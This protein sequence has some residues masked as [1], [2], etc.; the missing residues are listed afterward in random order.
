LFQLF[1][2]VVI[3][4]QVYRGLLL[5]GKPT[6]FGAQAQ[7]GAALSS[8][9][10]FDLNMKITGGKLASTFGPEAYFRVVPQSHSTFQGNFATSFS[11]DKPLTNLRALQG[12]LPASVPEPS[13]LWVF[14]MGGTGFVAVRWLNDRKIRR[15][16]NAVARGNR[17]KGPENRG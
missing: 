14:L 11:G 13:P 12:I 7:Q 5:E 9:D 2:T 10:V 15:S 3:G 16:R 17:S 1:G 4:N 8:A 6:A